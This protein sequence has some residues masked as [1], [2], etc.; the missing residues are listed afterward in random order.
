MIPLL[1]SVALAGPPPGGVTPPGKVCAERS[2]DDQAA[3]VAELEA[4]Y[5]DELAEATARSQG[6]KV[7]DRSVQRANTVLSMEGKGELCTADQQFWGAMVLLNATKESAAAQAYHLGEHLVQAR[8]ARGPWLA[9]VAYDRWAVSQGSLQFYGSQ[10]R[11]ADGKVCLY[12]V[13][14]AFPDDRRVSYGHPSLEDVI[15]KVLEVNGRAGDEPTVQRLKHLD[16]WC[17]PVPW[18][19]K[20][21]DLEDPYGR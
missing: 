8:Y 15:A 5:D 7:K 10:T 2:D 6:E 3:V 11:A 1:L 21:S 4:M 20:K 14:P 12:W 13:D 18:S 19:G 17:K 9:A 16:L